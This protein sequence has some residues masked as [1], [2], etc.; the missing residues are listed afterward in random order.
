[1]NVILIVEDDFPNYLLIKNYLEATNAITILAKNGIEAVEYVR[2]NPDISLVLMDLSMP[3]MDG[4]YATKL[5]KSIRA[6]LPVIVQ[7]AYLAEDNNA[8][9]REAGFD[10]YIRKP[11]SAND[12]LS[13]ITPFLK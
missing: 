4:F 12:L 7:T 1:M 2:N 8:Q 10:A 11:Y 6:S 5:I 3:A 13:I 9:I